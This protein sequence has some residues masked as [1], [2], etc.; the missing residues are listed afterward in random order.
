MTGATDREYPA[1]PLVGVGAVV[2]IT[3]A[4]RDLLDLAGDVPECGV[5][6]VRRRFPPLAGQW[7][8]PGGILEVGETLSAGLTR[9]VAEETGLAVDPG[10]VVEVLDRIIRDPEG[11]V[12]Y[13]F[14][15]VDYLCRPAGGRLQASSDAAEVV[16]A[17]AR[18]LHPFAMAAEAEAVIQRAVTMART[19]P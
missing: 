5:L 4:H 12:R 14:V 10:P 7:S 18:A 9:E 19:P 8:L 17:D 13:H 11:R 6:L 3:P 1:R 16:I 2:L 15:L